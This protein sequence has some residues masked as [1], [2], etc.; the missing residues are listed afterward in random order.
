MQH[1]R[2]G[3]ISGMLGVC[4]W[5]ATRR[6]CWRGVIIKK[7]VGYHSKGLRILGL[8]RLRARIVIRLA[9]LLS[10]WLSSLPVWSSLLSIWPIC[11]YDDLPSWSFRWYSLSINSRCP[12]RSHLLLIILKHFLWVLGPLYVTFV[13]DNT[14]IDLLLCWQS[15]MWLIKA[16]FFMILSIFIVLVSFHLSWV[17]SVLTAFGYDDPWF[18]AKLSLVLAQ[19]LNTVVLHVLSFIQD[20][21]I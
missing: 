7:I 12:K 4:I 10:T 2:S 1:I 18:R 13:H 11:V 6:G 8:I 15:S 19:V 9:L 3:L 14:L 17:R 21:L 5:C 16:L 20:L